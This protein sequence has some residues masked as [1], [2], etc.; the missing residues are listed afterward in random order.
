M[1]KIKNSWQKHGLAYTENEIYLVLNA[2]IHSWPRL[3][4]WI[5]KINFYLELRVLTCKGENFSNIILNIKKQWQHESLVLTKI[6][7]NHWDK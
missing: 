5:S 4:P 1:Y 7:G 2:D 3:L 6:G